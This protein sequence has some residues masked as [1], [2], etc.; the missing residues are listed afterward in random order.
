M[1][2]LL[3]KNFKYRA[4]CRPLNSRYG[5][6]PTYPEAIGTGRSSRCNT[7]NLTLFKIDEFGFAK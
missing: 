3:Y 4:A 7:Q 6:S 1:Y 5:T 2:K